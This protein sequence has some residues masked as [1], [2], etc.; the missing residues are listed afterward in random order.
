MQT[1]FFNVSFYGLMPYNNAF[2][3]A[4]GMAL[5]VALQTLSTFSVMIVL[6]MSRLYPYSSDDSTMYTYCKTS[7]PIGLFM[8]N[9]IIKW[10]NDSDLAR[11][12]KKLDRH[13]QRHSAA[14]QRLSG[15]DQRLSGHDQRLSGHDQRLSGHDQRLSGHDRRF[16]EMDGTRFQEFQWKLIADK[17]D[18]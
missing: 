9:M 13:D 4:C 10:A 1:Y 6:L 17:T 2:E 5:T 18:E 12:K 11:I 3:E 16:L 15:H 8:I 7:I 14:E